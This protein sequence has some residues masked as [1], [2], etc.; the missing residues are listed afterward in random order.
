MA[1][2]SRIQGP[3]ELE[4]L[5]KIV[6]WAFG[7]PVAGTTKWLTDARLENVRVARQHEKVVGG[8]VQIPMGQWFG[9]RSVPTLGIA[10]VAVDPAARGRG[11]A[12]AMMRETL[13]EARARGIAL[14]TLYPATVSLYR[15]AGYEL[16][17]SY[18]RYSVRAADCPKKPSTL[19]LGAIREEDAPEI[20]DAYRKLAREQPGYLDRCEYVWRRV[21]APQGETARGYVVRGES[22]VEGYAYLLQQGNVTSA[23]NLLLSDLIALTPGALAALLSLFADHRSTVDNICLLYT[24]DAADEL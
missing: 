4:A 23:Q 6:S 5:S 21:R 8:L 7:F 10:G 2:A 16:A 14:S 20:E 11:V 24:S 22:G 15:A 17:G 9:G 13:A 18:C 12:L 1:G 3:D 19:E